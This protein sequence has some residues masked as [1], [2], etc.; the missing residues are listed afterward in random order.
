MAAERSRRSSLVKTG[1]SAGAP[2]ARGRSAVCP[3]RGRL[4]HAAERVEDARG[5]R[6]R[7]GGGADWPGDRAADAVPEPRPGREDGPAG[8]V[9][10]PAAHGPGRGRAA[11]RLP[12]RHRRVAHLRL[13]AGVRVGPHRRGRTPGLREGRVD[14]GAADV[15]RGLP[16]GGAQA[17]GAPR[18]RTRRPARW[19][20]DV[21]DWFVLCLEHVESRQPRRPWRQPDLDAAL[22][23]LEIV[24]DSA[25]A[26]SG[27]AG[28]RHAGRGVRRLPRLLGPPARSGCATSTT[29]RRPRRWPPATRRSSAGDTLVHTDVRDDNVLLRPDGTALL[30]DWN[31]PCVGADWLDTLLMLVGPRG[32][33]LDVEAVLASRRLPARRP[34]REHRHRARAGDRLLPAAG[35]RAGALDLAARP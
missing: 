25:H 14:Q 13:H 4:G 20:L 22:D 34:G 15:R 1:P 18:R 2:R 29:S 16:R 28:T 12:R 9:D 32:D 10:A 24:A 8:R 23:A 17:R 3:P 35:G 33:G 11:P 7:P 27:R 21:D 19:T 6:R 31:F 30:C 5:R 26:R